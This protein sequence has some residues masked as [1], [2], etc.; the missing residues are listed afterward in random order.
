MVLD[1]PRTP[2]PPRKRRRLSSGGEGTTPGS[3]ASER[4]GPPGWA[5]IALVVAALVMAVLIG[6]HHLGELLI[7]RDPSLAVMVN[8]GS[9]RAWSAH[10]ERL[11]ANAGEDTRQRAEAEA[12]PSTRKAA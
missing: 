6:R 1:D 9:H 10:A 7:S 11:I 5:R 3:P 2:P 8:G 12:R 4:K